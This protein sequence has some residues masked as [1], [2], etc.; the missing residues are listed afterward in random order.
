MAWLLLAALA[1]SAPATG[2]VY[3]SLDLDRCR[4]LDRIEEGESV[5]WR[6]AGHAG[7]A[8]FVGAG[9]GR[10][11]IDAGVDNGEWES[12]PEMNRPGPRVE[13]RLR[14]GR[15]IAVIF[16]LIS[17][18]AEQPA[19]SILM[20]ETIGRDGRPGCPI[21]LVGGALPDANALARS[22]ADRRAATFRCGRDASELHG[23]D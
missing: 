1:A 23:A 2:S 9:D 19:R 17:A 5:R 3:T 13:W 4:L 11:D 22:I 7:I 6:C 15:P 18:D 8:L 20:V 10:F 12:L 21:G 14:A 16:R